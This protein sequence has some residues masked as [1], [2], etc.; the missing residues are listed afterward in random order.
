LISGARALGRACPPLLLQGPPGHGKSTLAVA[1]AAAYGS[2]AHVLHAGR[3]T[4]VI[5]ICKLL[6][7]VR[8]GDF[9]IIDE[10]HS[11]SQDA[12]QVL[13][14]ALDSEKAPSHEDNRLDRTK[15]VSI[16]AFTLVLASNEPGR[17]RKALRERLHRVDFDPY[18]IDELKQIAVRVAELEEVELTAQAVRRLAEVAQ[19]SPRLIAKRTELLRYF[20]PE[21]DV[22]NKEDI[23]QLL[24]HQGVDEKGLYPQQRLYLLTLKTIH[25]GRLKLEHLAVKLGCDLVTLRQDIEPYLFELGLVELLSGGQRLLTEAGSEL[26]HEMEPV[27]EES[28]AEDSS[29]PAKS[30]EATP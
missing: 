25:G 27:V 2:P 1:V 20:S 26:A 19:G 24:S 18:S 22:F 6:A 9:L 16:A 29:A 7:K 8:C 12:Q 11:L 15:P 10:A 23:D 30:V 21:K 17:I 13:H 5:H 4:R 14:F 28:Q 3:D